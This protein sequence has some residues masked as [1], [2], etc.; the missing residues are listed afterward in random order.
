MRITS[1]LTTSLILLTSCASD[2]PPP[3]DSATPT[4]T[5]GPM[6]GRI[7][8]DRVGVWARTARPGEFRVFYGTAPDQLT[9]STDP[10]TTTLD[11]DNSNWVQIDG[12]ESNTKHYYAVSTTDT[13]T[14]EDRLS[15]H[16]HTLPA[17][18]DFV[19]AEA[20]PK[21]L[22]NFRFEF[23]CGNN[24]REGPGGAYG[25][26]LPTFDTM[27]DRLTRKDEPSKIDFAILNGDWLYEDKRDFTP[28]A[29]REQVGIAQADD[30]RPVRL[31][32]GIVGVWENYKVFLERAPNLSEWH[33]YVPSYYTFDDHELLSDVYGAGEVGRRNWKSVFRDVA[34]RAWYDYLGWSNE[35]P[36]THPGHRI[37]RSPTRILQRHSH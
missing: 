17:D 34:T 10:I 25:A 16:F 18:T 29:W 33:R 8:S 19:D 15:G 13:P 22:F 30:P 5:H 28:E 11:N 27:I 6:L 32:P 12:L 24:Q 4:I 23:A 1:I 14:A 9:T 7:G 3:V 35:V 36:P 20:N 21:G 2:G 31:M 37:R 26:A